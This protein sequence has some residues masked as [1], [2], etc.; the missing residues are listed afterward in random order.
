MP[1][2]SSILT[3][4]ANAV[5]TITPAQGY[6][7]TV[8][9]ANV[10]TSVDS[11][12]QQVQLTGDKYPRFFVLTDGAVYEGLPTHAFIKHE[13]FTV[14]AVFAKDNS[15]P[16]APSLSAQVAAF[17]DDFERMI[18]RNSQLGGADLASIDKYATDISVNDPEAVAVFELTID[19]RRRF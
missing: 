2:S 12:N 16:D 18:D 3:A 15:A 6:Q 1:T 17:V 10:F 14:I 5:K 9:S 11:L 13:K 7:T 19:F 8:N 4:L